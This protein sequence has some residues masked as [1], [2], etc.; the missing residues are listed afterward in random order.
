MVM[1]DSEPILLYFYIV[2]LNWNVDL[3][4]FENSLLRKFSAFGFDQGKMEHCALLFQF[5][6][7]TI[8]A[9]Q[10]EAFKIRSATMTL[11]TVMKK[12]TKAKYGDIIEN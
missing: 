5:V 4:T 2:K 3:S 10:A 1:F 9:H 8:E 11:A 12:I 6:Q 7:N